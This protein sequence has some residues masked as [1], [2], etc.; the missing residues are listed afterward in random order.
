MKFLSKLLLMV[1]ILALTLSNA[2]ADPLRVFIRGGAKTHGPNQHDHP[3]F[4]KEWTQLLGERGM[5]V[6][7]DMDFP[8]PQQLD[9]TDVLIIYAADG[10][11]I[12]GERRVQLEKFLQRGGGLVVLHDGVV[13][14][15]QHEWCKSIIGGA[16]RW[17]SADMPQAKATKWYEGDVG[18]C[19][20]DMTNAISKGISNFDWKD[21]VYFDMDISPE[22]SV[23]ATSMHNVHIIAPQI[24]TYE[25]TL[26][27][28]S[29]PYRAFVS[30]P[31][32]EYD[33]FNTPHYRAILMRGIAWAGKRANVDEF[34]SKEELGS[35]VYPA[36]GPLPS[37]EA[38]KTFSLHPEFDISVVADEKIAEKLMSVEWDPKGRLWVVETP[39]YPNGRQIHQNDSKI[40]PWRLK[41]PA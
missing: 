13:S 2:A 33:V 19:W 1:S 39:E 37:A 11:S 16:W 29:T 17:P 20:V 14:G 41:D 7:G 28:G 22:V 40:T 6:S 25:K 18:I 15:D 4:L 12:K 36:G 30:I 23:L 32:H 21:E 31:G 9:N 34:C 27:G 10:M 35:L 8:E 26:P 24:W 5:K 3:R 38:L